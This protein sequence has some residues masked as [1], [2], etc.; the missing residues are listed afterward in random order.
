MIRTPPLALRNRLAEIVLRA[1]R[2]SGAHGELRRLASEPGALEAWAPGA[3]AVDLTLARARAERACEA[4]TARPALTDDSS[5][6]DTLAA[7]ACLYDAG[8][9]FEVHE[10]LEPF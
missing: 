2:D 3:P 5:L 1:L 10:L 7:A 6:G 8:L 4:L 9:Y